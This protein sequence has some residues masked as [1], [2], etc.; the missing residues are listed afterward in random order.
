MVACAAACAACP[1]GHGAGERQGPR[2]PGQ[3]GRRPGAPGARAGPGVPLEVPPA[4]PRGRAARRAR[5]GGAHGQV[6]AL[7]GRQGPVARAGGSCGAR[8]VH[9]PPAPARGLARPPGRRALRQGGHRGVCVCPRQ[10]L[11]RRPQDQGGRPAARPRRSQDGR[12]GVRAPAESEA[13]VL[14]MA[15][16]S[17]PHETSGAP[18]IHDPPTSDLARLT[19]CRCTHMTATCRIRLV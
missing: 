4:G 18:G 6:C 2:E 13:L 9:L 8:V 19:R 16:Q 14:C 11:H 3:G 12:R 5:G 1:G 7:R 10:R 17:V 15:R